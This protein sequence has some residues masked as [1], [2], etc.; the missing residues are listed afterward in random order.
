M[1]SPKGSTGRYV[2]G[3]SIIGPVFL[4]LLIGFLFRTIFLHQGVLYGWDT[5]GELY[6][7]YSWT[8]STLRHGDLPLW[9]PSFLSGYPFYASSASTVCYP[10]NFFFL[11]LPPATAINASFLLH[12]FLFTC[13]FFLFL[14]KVGLT[15]F[16][17]LFGAATLGWSEFL[18]TRVYTGELYHLYTVT[19]FPCSLF[20]LEH[21]LQNQRLRVYLLVAVAIALQITAGHLQYVCYCL[22]GLAVYL[23]ARLFLTSRE[24]PL[25]QPPQRGLHLLG[26]SLSICLGIGIASI[27]WFPTVELMTYSGRAHGISYDAATAISF[28][29]SHLIKLFLPSF[30]GDEVRHEYWGES[31]FALCPL[32]IGV[33]PALLALRAMAYKDHKG[34]TKAFVLLG[35][36]GLIGAMGRYLPFY[37]WC[38]AHI[39]LLA[40][41]R[42]PARMSFLV[43]F[44]LCALAAIGCQ[45]VLEE[46]SLDRNVQLQSRWW[47]LL[48]VCTILV[49][50]LTV[51]W[52]TVG[53]ALPSIWRAAVGI[54]FHIFPRFSRTLDP[55]DAAFFSE[56]FRVAGMSLLH[57]SFW[58][59][60][61]ALVYR[62]FL[63]ASG[64]RNHPT[65]RAIAVLTIS[66]VDL[67]GFSSRYLWICPENAL[68]WPKSLVSFFR[69]DTSLYR[70]H[71]EVPTKNTPLNPVMLTSYRISTKNN[72]LDIN[73]AMLYGLYH[74]GGEIGL[75]PSRYLQFTGTIDQPGV[76]HIH[77]RSALNLLN[78]KYLVLPSGV[79]P[80]L[81]GFEP[82]Y[83][84]EHYAVFRNA[85][86][87]ERVRV[88]HQGVFLSDS[89]QVLVQLN[90]P[91]HDPNTMVLLE[92]PPHGDATLPRDP[93]I[94]PD[95]PPSRDTIS[96][97]AYCS[98][99]I[100][101]ETVLSQPGYLVLNDPY[102]PGWKV[103]VD[104]RPCTLLRADFL[105]RA[106]PLSEGKHVV[107]FRFVP[108]VLL[109]G[110]MVS[111]CST[112]TLAVLALVPIF[113][114]RLRQ[115]KALTK[116]RY[117]ISA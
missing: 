65:M 49:V 30:F 89:A 44:A 96:I 54:H 45:K 63:V 56:T 12:A 100:E 99:K 60:I 67:Y 35:L 26:C 82:V 72:E 70:I 28:P 10:F 15:P 115:K 58:L 50:L 34:A 88:V 78:V 114:G 66:L 80:N 2:P 105:F 75:I 104:S 39:P 97:R 7:W 117:P 18:V 47:K 3:W 84:D 76:Y 48:A 68:L 92:G 86:Y 116:T 25:A 93:P 16:A 102:Y 69:S 29:P 23:C 14:R 91:E 101:V 24:G 81:D 41:F 110:A 4:V 40:L 112:L 87:I 38:F 109:A 9:N 108:K 90:Q 73:R 74:V 22:L 103:W 33:L 94:E 61:S 83:E 111:T 36:I 64:P 59:S 43:T 20:F 37:R 57:L 11:F 19:W 52:H 79:T 46:T 27:Q 1:P 31:V 107:E 21:A 13:F 42:I 5:V 55:T 95:A 62:Y 113:R 6:Y 77:S 51:A 106:V 53:P 85:Q 8:F 71:S 17:S 98:R 32:Y